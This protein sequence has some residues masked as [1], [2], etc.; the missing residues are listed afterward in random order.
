[1]SNSI[2]LH[3]DDQPHVKTGFVA[4]SFDL[5]HAGHCLML[6]DAKSKCDYLIAALQVDPSIDRPEKNK[7]I[8]SMDER[9]LVLSA[10]RCVDEVVFYSTEKEL[11][12]IIQ[13]LKP[14]IRILGMDWAG[15]SYTGEGLTAEVYYHPR[16][17]EYST[18][19]LR[20]KIYEEEAKNYG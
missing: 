4:S 2:T 3:L 16:D 13:L 7:P 5:L 12:E 18:S 14:D 20:R 15:K 17:H 9:Y 19:G 11:R 8:Q 1:M 10:N 6:A